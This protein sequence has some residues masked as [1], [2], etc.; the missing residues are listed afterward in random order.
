M[1]LSLRA[2]LITKTTRA[3]Y[4]QERFGLFYPQFGC[5]FSLVR[6]FGCNFG[7]PV[8]R[9]EFGVVAYVHGQWF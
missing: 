3:Q 8:S 9:D 4:D 6:H 7:E 5:D 2:W 1:W